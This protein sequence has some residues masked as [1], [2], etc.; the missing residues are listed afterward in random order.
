MPV[1]TTKTHQGTITTADLKSLHLDKET[2][3]IINGNQRWQE[4]TGGLIV[5]A[6]YSIDGEDRSVTK[7]V[8]AAQVATMTLAQM[9]AAAHALMKAELK[10]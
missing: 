8:T 3:E 9:V 6:T 1:T 7:V 4:E 10:V 5:K 2:R